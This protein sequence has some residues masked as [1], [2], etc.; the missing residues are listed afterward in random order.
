MAAHRY[1]RRVLLQLLDPDCSRYLPPHLRAFL[2]PAQPAAAQV[3]SLELGCTACAGHNAQTAITRAHV[4]AYVQ[5][6]DAEGVALG[7]SKK[8]Q[9][10]RRAELLG[11]GTKSLAAALT[12]ACREHACA[13]LRSP[14]ACDVLVEVARGSAGGEGHV[15]ATFLWPECLFATGP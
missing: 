3:M 4:L 8:S 13:W 14:T 6:A 5:S 15:L 9:D 1:G 11:T 10:A 2:H 7:G 12:S